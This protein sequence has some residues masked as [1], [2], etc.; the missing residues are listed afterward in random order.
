MLKSFLALTNLK[1]ASPKVVSRLSLQKRLKGSFDADFYRFMH[2]SLRARE[3]RELFQH[4]ITTGWQQNFDPS[5]E[6]SVS[7]YFSQNPDVQEA[8]I[9][10]L[11]HYITVGK[12]E[13]RK[14]CLSLWGNASS[15]I[16][17]A[18]YLDKVINEIDISHVK[19]QLPSDF[20][21]FSDRAITSYFLVLGDKLKLSPKRDFDTETY[22]ANNPDVAEHGR[23]A[24]LHFCLA[25]R[26]EGRKSHS[27]TS[28][29]KGAD[30]NVRIEYELNKIKP[31]FDAN[32]YRRTYA[33]MI[34]ETDDGALKHFVI[35]GWREGRDPAENFSVNG[36]LKQNP[37]LQG[38]DIN[39]FLDYLE[40][41]GSEQKILPRG[42]EKAPVNINQ[43]D[44]DIVRSHFNADFYRAQNEDVVGNDEQLLVHFMELGWLERRDPSPQFSVSYYLEKNP[45]IA[46]N[47]IN[48]FLH[49]VMFGQAEGRRP[50]GDEPME[51]VFN[52]KA[53]IIP[54]HL[55]SILRYPEKVKTKLRPPKRVNPEALDLH[56]VIPDFARG[57][58]GHMTI[59]RMIRHLEYMGHQCHIW[60]EN[61][62][63]HTSGQDA[64]EEIVKYFQCVEAQVNFVENGFF[65][66]KGD[67]AIAT[68]WTTA[69]LVDR[70]LGFAG[71]FYFVQDHEP[72]FYATGTESLL[73]RATYDLDLDCICASPWLARIMSQTYGRWARHFYLAY[74]HELYRIL[75]QAKHE[76]RFVSEL[77][78]PC[79]IAVYARDHT[80]RRCVYL[81]LMGLQLLGKTR[82]DFEVH[83][84]GQ[85][86]LP[87]TE[88]NFPA[89]NHGI[90]NANQLA[91]LYNDCHMG[92]CFSATNY[93]LVPQEMM[94][95]GLPLL[96]IDGDSTRSIFPDDAITLGGPDPADIATKLE[97]LLDH[98]NERQKQSKAA[99]DWVRGFSWRGAAEA[100][101]SA[102]KERMAERSTLAAPA[103]IKT[104]EIELDVVIP[105]YNGM[106][107]LEPVV[108][109]L[110][111]QRNF[112]ALQI[113][114]IDSSSSDGTTE[115]LRKQPDI[116]TTVIDQKTF[117]HG[118]TRNE[119]AALGTAPIIA[120]L[121][122]DAIPT[123]ASWA[124]DILK[125]F[126]HVPEAAGLFGRHEP[127]PDHPEYVR[128]EITQHFAN[129]LKHPLVLSKATDPEK[130]ASGDLGWRQLLHFYSD[131]NSAM[132][133]S[134]W[135]DI[136][137]PE[138]DYG[139]DQVW[140][141]DIIE[142]GYTKL[143]APTACVYHSH[144]YTPEET[145]KR[146]KTEGAFFYQH[147]GYELGADTPEALENA[148][149]NE[150]RRFRS[151]AAKRQIDDAEIE[152]RLANIA[153]KHR[154][155]RDGRL[156]IKAPV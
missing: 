148:I 19:Q 52:A 147:F 91:E 43:A 69:Y 80:A 108:E 85:D 116:S 121:T 54:K 120:F 152:L 64:W 45:D 2:P 35:F 100:T 135:N 7:T 28:R 70:A 57:S 12:S 10:P 89:V 56:W 151:W 140:A 49:F 87:F 103:T 132:R 83:F 68:G 18:H 76:A 36:H 133:R 106:G 9:D 95:C 1:K 24:F 27:D 144:D 5:A 110:R 143:Y 154:G 149:K 93:S 90:L 123:N 50:R 119:G 21:K 134:V 88:T 71:K 61:P 115:W 129:M 156:E 38:T 118:R 82:Q 41:E 142:A 92:I 105:T 4:Y 46:A 67:A 11:S 26:Y 40:R 53:E 66:A 124:P 111:Q 94:A 47:F 126:N 131:N 102:I 125:M 51:M 29:Q 146:S 60:I 3:N 107:E 145:Y 150:Q 16:I 74:D 72:E 84:F 153:E 13:G 96:E 139:E 128:Q 55:A 30:Q 44:L 136:P 6:F 31:F 137:Y 23:N 77:D 122:Q 65:E 59:L 104:R 138:V 99:L 141:R 8:G 37:D 14:A 32:F 34:D 15:G 20:A 81:A 25:G 127:Y 73:A 101:E 155:L 97:H 78:Q 130:W 109:S 22:L 112:D 62:V 98:P 33:D 42:P 39:P 63:F 79:K 48:P 86:E 58:G 113:H 17:E 114:C 75:D 117:Q